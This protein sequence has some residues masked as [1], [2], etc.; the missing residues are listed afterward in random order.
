M[1]RIK[2]YFARHRQL[3][4]GSDTHAVGTGH[5]TAST[6][7]DP[8]VRSCDG[9]EEPQH[10]PIKDS[11]STMGPLECVRAERVPAIEHVSSLEEL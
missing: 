6:P 8:D 10:F 2:E 4:K 11:E 5:I 1:N 9:M 3:P 7:E